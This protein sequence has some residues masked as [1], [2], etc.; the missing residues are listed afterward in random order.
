PVSECTEDEGVL[1]DESEYTDDHN[2]E[3]KLIPD[4]EPLEESLIAPLVVESSHASSDKE[5]SLIAPP[6]SECTEDEGV[7]EDESEYTDDHNEEVKLIPDEEPLEESLIAPLVV[8]S[9][10]AS[11]DKEES[12][13][14][15]PVSECTE[16]EGVLEDESEYT[17]DHNEEVEVS[18]DNEK[19]VAAAQND[20]MDTP[21]EDVSDETPRVNSA[22]L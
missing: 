11:S 15:P 9:S 7:L 22:I 19:E 18:E 12:L 4:E 10:H 2:E 17:D 8:E 3:V 5:E 13:I 20:E 21:S 6:V 1:E 16:D 14:A